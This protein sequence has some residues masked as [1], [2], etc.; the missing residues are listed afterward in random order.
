MK[1]RAVL[2]IIAAV[3]AAGCAG[4]TAGSVGA[5]G[6][7]SDGEAAAAPGTDAAA[8]EAAAETITPAEMREHIA[9]LA[10]DALAGRNTPS[11][12]LEAAAAYIAAA[13][14]SLGLRPAG[15][16][17]GYIQRYALQKR[18]VV[19]EETRVRFVGPEGAAALGFGTD[20]FV[21]PGVPGRVRGEVVYSG[22][23]K[24]ARP[25][26]A[27]R[28][29]IVVFELTGAPND[30]TL[31]RDLA[32]ADRAAEEAGAAARIVVL[33]VGFPAGVIQRAAEH[34]SLAA[35]LQVGEVEGLPTFFVSSAAGER[36]FEV[37]GTEPEAARAEAA[38]G[39]P[40]VLTGVTAELAAPVRVEEDHRVPNVVAVLPGSDPALR[41]TYVI[42]SA[43]FDHVGIRRPDETGDSIYNG[44][45]DNASGTAALLEVAEAFASLPTPPARSL[46]FLAVSGEEKGLL[47]SQYYSDHP[48]VPLEAIVADINVD[49]IGRNA[50]DS[51]VVIGQEYSS[52]GPLVNAVAA[53][54]PEL[55]LTVSRD[56]W[57]EQRFFFRSDHF[58]FARKEIPAL[59][60][61]AGVHEDYHR[62]SDQVEKIDTDKASRVAR[63]IFYTAN[64][65]AT[66]A[67]PPRWT[68][69]GLEEVRALTGGAR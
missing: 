13:F 44:A 58:N 19:A 9:Y 64:E 8:L 39:G 52:L 12:G 68:E 30:P 17:G 50:P 66:R 38:R 56:L 63:L 54:R 5:Q 4:G 18:A 29:R 67:E 47:G 34:Y 60:F 40:A 65:I 11:P 25:D 62:P 6:P 51:I 15:D 57:P 42:F 45:D 41:E 37:A 69:Q 33:P 2:S 43:H 24:D 3:V 16:A 7:A 14:D 26:A 32:R 46:V 22:A 10:S 35:G 61:F 27:M 21:I 23:A 48:T 59:F 1:S 49:M 55:G 31:N 20:F 53:A 36:L 28:G